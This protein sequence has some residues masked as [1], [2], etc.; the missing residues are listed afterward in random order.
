M[1]MEANTLGPPH[2]HLPGRHIFTISVT[3]AGR[4]WLGP[5]TFLSS[6]PS[7]RNP[8]TLGDV[9]RE[10]AEMTP[11]LPAE[12]EFLDSEAGE[13]WKRPFR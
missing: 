5:F 11:A 4:D 10:G 12:P 7:P 13:K 6:I 2:G 8:D 3:G 1:V 9:I